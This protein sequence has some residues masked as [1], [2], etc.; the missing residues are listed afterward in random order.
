MVRRLNLCA[1]GPKSAVKT[2]I[3][4]SPRVHSSSKEEFQII[5]GFFR[6]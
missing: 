6:S 2:G 5:G 3:R 1:F 4:E